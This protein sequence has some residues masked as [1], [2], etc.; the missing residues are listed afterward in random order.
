M[1]ERFATGFTSY[2]EKKMNT[3]IEKTKTNFHMLAKPSGP[4]CNLDCHYCFY[5]EKESLFE[6]KTPF[7]M[8]DET[9]R[10]LSKTIYMP[11]PQR[12]FLLC[13]KGRTDPIGFE[14]L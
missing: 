2:G 6:P 9:L 14:F 11:R 5:T 4:I 10:I 13:G 3:T 7:R 12:K 1:A 8:S